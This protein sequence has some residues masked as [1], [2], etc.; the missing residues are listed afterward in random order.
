MDECTTD[1]PG[2][3]RMERIWERNRAVCLDLLHQTSCAVL[4]AF[5]NISDTIEKDTAL[6]E[7][8]A[9][10]EEITRRQIQTYTE[11]I[12][13]ISAAEFEE[14]K[15]SQLKV[16]IGN[17]GDQLLCNIRDIADG[18]SEISPDPSPSQPAEESDNCQ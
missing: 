5:A 7:A 6:Q 9:K 17:W 14:P 3:V 1:C 4:K 13:H 2:V 8:V 18:Y 12:S 10:Q 16:L 11:S 15:V